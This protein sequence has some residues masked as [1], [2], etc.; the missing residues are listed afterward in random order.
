[1]FYLTN[2]HTRKLT[3]VI[4]SKLSPTSPIPQPRIIAGSLAA[5]DGFSIHTPTIFLQVSPCQSHTFHLYESVNIP[6]RLMR[7]LFLSF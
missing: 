3:P 6:N 4:W 2:P 7:L 5:C 1:M